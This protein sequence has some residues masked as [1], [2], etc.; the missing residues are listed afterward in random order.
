MGVVGSY[1]AWLHVN[2]QALII[3]S[4]HWGLGLVAAGEQLG[5]VKVTV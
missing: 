2:G 3:L 4:I 5:S 1:S